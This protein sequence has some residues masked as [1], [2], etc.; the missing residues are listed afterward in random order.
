MRVL[1]VHSYY[2]IRGGEDEVC[3]AEKSLLQ[4]IGHL[5]D[6]YEDN[7]ERIA[8]LGSARMLLR[9]VWSREA[10]KALSQKLRQQTYDVVHVHNFLPLISP[11]VYY[12][13]KTAGVP[14][15]Q[16]RHNYRLLCPNALF[17]REE[18]V[19]EDWFVKFIPWS[20]IRHACYRENH[21]ASGAVAAML[22]A[23]R[24]IHTWTEM[25]DTY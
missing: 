17:F 10:Y 6:V 16:T 1:S 18:R 21:A 12:A 8:A 9:T 22:T 3:E 19:C 23:H 20:G 25:V 5:V 11:S 15:V 13:A 7:N 14:V 24:L 2:K 4:L